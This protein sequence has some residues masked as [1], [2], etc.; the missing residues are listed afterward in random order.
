MSKSNEALRQHIKVSEGFR[1][2]PYTCPGGKL[3]IGYGFNLDDCGL[4]EVVANFWLDYLI[5]GVTDDL[6]ISLTNEVW[7]Q[8]PEFAKFVLTDICYNIGIGKLLKF[9]LMLRAIVDGDWQ[10]AANEMENSD[11]YYQVGN[12]SKKLVAIMRSG[13]ID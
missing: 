12:R 7:E 2:K 13:K 8:I 5:N 1:D 11:W 9:K 4:P 6:K 10:R 3:T